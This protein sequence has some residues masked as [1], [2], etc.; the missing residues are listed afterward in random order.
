M[1]KFP[2]AWAVMRNHPLRQ[3]KIDGNLDY[4]SQLVDGK[5]ANLMQ[6][7]VGRHNIPGC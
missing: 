7:I 3:D 6:D 5:K 4:L 1:K 2:N